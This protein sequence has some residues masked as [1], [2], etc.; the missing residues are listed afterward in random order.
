M[1]ARTFYDCQQ[2]LLGQGVILSFTGYVT[3][4]VLYSLGEALKQKMMLDDADSNT[5]K[6]VFSV[7]VEQ[8]QNMIRY[9]A[10]RQEG[11]GDPKIEL[12]A[13][14]ITVGRSDGR[15]FVVCG[16]E[17]ANSDVPQLQA[18]LAKIAA[19]D[20]EQLKAYYREKLKE[21]PEAQSKGASIGLIEIARRAAEPIEFDFY[22]LGDA[23]S[24]YC[25]KA[26]V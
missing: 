9:S 24:F 15:F 16:N 20:K 8:V 13:G 11:A 14:M 4:G 25:L 23:Q 10:M 22:R 6:R 1:L 26:Y 5:A 21:E 17:V 7:F 18:R 3:E 19:M 2:S 12:S